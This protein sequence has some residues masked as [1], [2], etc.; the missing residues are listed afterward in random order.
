LLVIFIRSV[1]AFCWGVINHIIPPYSFFT[2]K[3]VKLIWYKLQSIA[4]SKHVKFGYLLISNHGVPL[5][6]FIKIFSSTFQNINPHSSWKIV[7]YNKEIRPSTMSLIS[8]LSISNYFHPF[9]NC[10]FFFKIFVIPCSIVVVKT[11]RSNILVDKLF[12]LTFETYFTSCNKISCCQTSLTS[13]TL[14][15]AFYRLNCFQEELCLILLVIRSQRTNLLS[16]CVSG[17]HELAPLYVETNDT[18]T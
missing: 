9:N 4:N 18:N 1:R 5:I 2:T 15:F 6:K 17:F 7:Y 11:K 16:T 12:F 13:P 10:R 3:I 14:C 8:C